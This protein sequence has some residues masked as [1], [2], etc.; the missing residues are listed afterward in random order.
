MECSRLKV[1]KEILQLHA[2]PSPT[3]ARLGFA[4]KGHIGVKEITRSSDKTGTW[5]EIKVSY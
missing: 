2:I 3:D 5:A 1:T 4:L